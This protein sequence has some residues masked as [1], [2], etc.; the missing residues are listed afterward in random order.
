VFASPAVGESRAADAARPRERIMGER[1]IVCP[2][3]LCRVTVPSGYGRG[4]I[5]CSGGHVLALE[6]PRRERGDRRRDW[7]LL[8]AAALLMAMAVAA[9]AWPLHLGVVR[10]LHG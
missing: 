5:S 3:C 6:R 8:V 10:H 9:T 7:P 2:I 4:T 1:V